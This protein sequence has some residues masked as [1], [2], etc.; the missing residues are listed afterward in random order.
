MRRI[1]LTLLMLF[2]LTVMSGCF[3]RSTESISVKDKQGRTGVKDSGAEQ[4]KDKKKK[5]LSSG[6]VPAD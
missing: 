1:S 3:S 2:G 4:G 6:A 5:G